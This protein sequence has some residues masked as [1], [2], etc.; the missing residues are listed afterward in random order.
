MN[1]IATAA[2]RIGALS[3]VAGASGLITACG[4]TAPA[5]TPT[6][7][8]TTTVPATGHAVAATSP[9]A[10]APPAQSGPAGC[11]SSD[12]QAKLGASQGTAG[13]IYQLV[14]LTNIS[15]SACTLYG[16]PGVSFVTG[17]GG[18]IIGAPATRNAATGDKLVILTPGGQ[19]YS[20]VGVVDVGALSASKCQPGKAD[21]L[22]V[23]APGDTGALYVRYSSQVCTRATVKFLTV[24]AVR[25]GSGGNS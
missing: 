17:P 20:A 19:A 23:Y 3:A 24:T 6:K 9:A 16:Y 14:V 5:A 12:L 4:T 25:P 15:G 22:Q 2:R 7:T 21:W 18:S 10:S 1:T 13:T 11:L 8:V